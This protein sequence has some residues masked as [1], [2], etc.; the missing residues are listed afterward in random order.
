MQC[1]NCGGPFEWAGQNARCMRCLSLFAAEGGQL[2]P[3]VVAAPG[4]GYNPEFNAMFARNLGFGPPPPGAQPVPPPQQ[5]PNA[6]LAKGNFEMG[7][8]WR[9]QVKVD[10]KTPEDFLKHKASSM[11]WGWII[12]AVIVGIVVLT[13]VGVGIYVYVVA[14]DSGAGGG[15]TARTASAGKWDGKTTF[16]CSGNDAISLSGVTANVSGTA[17][18]ASGNC[19]LTLSGVEITAPTG[20]DASASAKVT[21]TGGSITS[22]TRAVNAAANAQ[23][24]FVGTRV[25][26]KVDKAGAAKV[27]GVK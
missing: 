27:I 11:I 4:G 25:S 26:G 3:I 24:T 14:K 2:T 13:F 6:D 8:G 12:G 5:R 20:I 23:V 18:R 17:I 15:A 7:D 21:M 10:G 9:L 16:E 19:Q 22:S 1:L